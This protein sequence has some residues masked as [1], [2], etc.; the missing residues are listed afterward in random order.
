M[1]QHNLSP[2]VVVAFLCW[3]L[4]P[5]PARAAGPCKDIPVRVTVY[6]NAVVDPATGG[7]VPTA[8]QPDA[9]GEYINGKSAS[10]LIKICSGTNDA[11]LNVS[12][13]KRTFTFAFGAPIDGSVVQGMPSW[14]PGR[15]AVSGWINIR[16]ITFSKQPFTTHMGATFTGPD[17]ATYRLGLDP[18]GVDA[19]DLHSGSELSAIDNTPYSTSPAVVYPSYPAVC[20]SGTM[21]TWLVRG[22]TPNSSGMLEVAT[23]HKVPT[24]GSQ[25]HQGQ[26]SMPFEMRIE[27]MQCFAY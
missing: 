26:Y 5:S 25:I 10:A 17:R 20:A 22:T 7:T 2:A 19:P 18:Y 3:S 24:N 23:L 11:V 8:L 4:C 1:T 12:G 13:T 6:T 9:A 14:V 16:N 27:A 21:P 15:Y